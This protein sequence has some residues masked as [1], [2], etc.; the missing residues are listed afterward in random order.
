MATKDLFS[1]IKWKKDTAANWSTNDPV[2][3]DGEI[4]IVQTASGEER[5]K[6]GN[7]TSRFTQL[8][9]QD[10]AVRNLIATMMPIA[11]GTFT[12]N[13]VATATQDKQVGM[14]RNIFIVDGAPDNSMGNDGDICFSL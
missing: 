4:V 8:P 1:R 3:L 10:E 9:F 14:I 13:V 11:G 7:G 12:G 5:F 2:L 6:I